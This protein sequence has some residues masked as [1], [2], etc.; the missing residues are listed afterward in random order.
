MN[1]DTSD[2]LLPN[3]QYRYAENVRPITDK[4]QYTGEL[5]LVEGVLPVNVL[6]DD[7]EILSFSSIRNYL[8]YITKEGNGW[9]IYRY[10]KD[11][12]SQ[13]LIFGRCTDELLWDD[14]H[15]YYEH[16]IRTVLRWESNKNIK[17]YIA[18]GIHEVLSVNIAKIN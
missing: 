12:S 9:N 4:D 14:D 11:S 3:D 2:F 15:P 1:S 5:H 16:H 7:E 6:K 10:D 8:V 17:L 13:E 18:D